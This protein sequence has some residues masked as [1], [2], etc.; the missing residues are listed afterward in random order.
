M[1]RRAVCAVSAV[2]VEAHPL[3]KQEQKQPC[4]A[5]KGKWI[6]TEERDSP[7]WLEIIEPPVFLGLGEGWLFTLRG[8]DGEPQ[9][10]PVRKPLVWVRDNEEGDAVAQTEAE[11]SQL[12]D[13][14]HWGMQLYLWD[15]DRF[16]AEGWFTILY[17]V[18]KF[19]DKQP[20]IRMTVEI[21]GKPAVV[22]LKIGE[23]VSLRKA[24]DGG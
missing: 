1:L 5:V 20:Y 6:L 14:A 2:V 21:D 16:P 8:N 3:P 19:E 23:M 11:A 12:T 24:E 13:E 18:Q 4:F 15:A 10:Y 22:R 9:P 7:V 17:A